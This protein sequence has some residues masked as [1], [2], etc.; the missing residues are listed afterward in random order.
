MH[1]MEFER[2]W[3]VADPTVVL[4]HRP[5][6]VSQA[7]LAVTGAW[8]VRIR[9]AFYVGETRADQEGHNTLTIK[10]PRNGIGRPEYEWEIPVELAMDLYRASEWKVVKARY[11]LI[12]ARMTWDVDVFYHD[13]EGL[14]VAECEVR[15]PS[16]VINPPPW[17]GMEVTGDPRYDNERLAQFPYASWFRERDR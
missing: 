11:Q 6:M 12:D 3:L 2:K 8:S 10:G 16:T 17:C 4:G 7:Y 5:T 15:D 13:N 9:R 1:Q 14:I